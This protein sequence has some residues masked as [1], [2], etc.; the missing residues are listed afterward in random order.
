VTDCS[1]CASFL[2]KYPDIFADYE[3]HETAKKIASRFR[4]MV[5]FFF[6]N[7]IATA[8]HDPVVVTYHDLC[9]ASRDQKLVKEP[10][11]ILKKYRELSTEICPRRIGAA[12]E[13]VLMPCLTMIS[14]ASLWIA[15][16][17]I[18]RKPVPICW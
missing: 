14:P 18:S 13:P 15:K 17:R 1:S 16:W 11:E 3:R 9:H 4:D 7:S 6:S 8:A 5:E 12:G 10:R 2:R